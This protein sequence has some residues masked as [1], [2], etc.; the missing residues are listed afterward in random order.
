M[1][2]KREEY[3]KAYNKLLCILG[4]IVAI[5]TIFINHFDQFLLVDLVVQIF[6]P[7]VVVGYLIMKYFQLKIHAKYRLL[8][9]FFLI[10]LL[11]YATI[12]KFL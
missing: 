7:A 6:F 2:Q 12:L 1:V 4:L 9:L 11:L 3:N 10:L 5:Y 8:F